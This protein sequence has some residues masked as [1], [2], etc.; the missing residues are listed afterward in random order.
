MIRQPTTPM[1]AIALTLVALAWTAGSPSALAA[2]APAAGVS[3]A[4][5]QPTGQEPPD[6]FMPV[7]SL[8]QQEQLPAAPLLMTAYGFV[9]AVLL[10]YLW[11]IWRRLMKVER[12][13]HD[14]SARLAEKPGAG[15]K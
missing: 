3:Q 5:A 10:V 9:W 8:P 7:K 15:A 13:V 11:S 4:A 6:Q 2:P 14:L 12:E 1:V